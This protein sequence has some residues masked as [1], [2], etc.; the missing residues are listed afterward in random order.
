MDN[1]QERAAYSSG[2]AAFEEG[3][4]I[5]EDV[6]ARQEKCVNFDQISMEV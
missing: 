1:R 4:I 6:I 3:E 5:A 2:G